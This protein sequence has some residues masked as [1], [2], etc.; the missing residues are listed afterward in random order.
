MLKLYN[1]LTNKKQD[2]IPIN[3]GSASI[4]SCGPT[5]YDRIHAGNIRAFLMPDL[6]QRVL[7][8]LE[9]L[10]VDWVM[11]ITDIDDRMIARASESYPNQEPLDAINKLADK[12]TDI[13]LDD[14]EKV[15]I[16][17]DDISH[18]PRA[19]DFIAPIQTIITQL[20]SDGIGYVSDGSVYFSVK[21]Y[22]ASGKTYGRLVSL[23]F[24]ARA[25]V[26]NDQDQKEGVADF[27]LWKAHKPGEPFWDFNISGKNYPGRPG[28]HIECSA[29]ST[30]FLGQPF[31]I[32]T[33]GVDLKFPHHENELAQCGGTQANYYIHN[34]HLSIKSQKMSKS[35]GNI[36]TLKDINDPMALRYLI[37]SAHYRS[38]MDFCL[39][40]ISS[41]EERLKNIRTYTDQLMLARV[42]QLPEADDTGK[43]K[44]FITEFKQALSDDLNTPKALSA[45]RLIEGKVYT[46]DAREAMRLVDDIM[47]LGII[48]DNPLSS[49]VLEVIDSYELARK[50]KNFSLSDS[51]RAKLLSQHGLVAS[52]T[53]VGTLVHRAQ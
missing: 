31:D 36:M 9:G 20:I 46:V 21:N 26:T 11:N 16:R 23:D 40:D 30:E 32:H 15:G 1:S 13:F 12:Y 5:V 33:G 38:Q 52:D 39:A 44:Q 24:S 45:L 51:L 2:F 8:R 25:R 19:T 48:V 10:N 47:G 29:M 27:V 3:P 17:R 37:L 28:W 18:L 50:D 22:I 6:L 53:Q 49:E 34:E 4:Y 14:I 41:A 42:G 43:T 7:A 35:L